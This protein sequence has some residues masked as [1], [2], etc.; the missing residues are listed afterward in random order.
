MNK[1]DVKKP[2][3]SNRLILNRSVS[4]RSKPKLTTGLHLAKL[5]QGSAR[6]RLR[7]IALGWVVVAMLEVTAYTVLAIAIRDGSGVV[8][9]LLAAAIA[10]I[11]TVAV[12]RAGYLAGAKLA[13]DLYQ[14]MGAS[15]SRAKLAWFTEDHRALVSTAAGRSVPVLMG[16]PAHQLQT[17]ILAPLVPLL[18]VLSIAIVSGVRAAFL[19]FALLVIALGMQVLAQRSLAR[20]DQARHELEQGADAATLELVDQLELLRTAAGS[21]RALD[22]ASDAWQKQESAMARSNSAAAPATA[23]SALA[24]VL[25]LAGVLCLLVWGGGFSQPAAALALIVLAARASAPLDELALIGISLNTLQAHTFAYREV[26]GAPALVQPAADQSRMPDG[27]ELRLQSVSHGPVIR[28]LDATVP[29]GST[30]HIAGPSGS[31]KSTLCGLLMRFDDPDAGRVLL[32]GVELSE[33]A[34]PELCSRMAYVSQHPVVFSGT[35]AE[36]VRIGRPEA[37]DDEVIDALAS[38][39]LAELVSRDNNGIYQ[40]VGTH[41]QALSG[42]ERQRVAIARALLKNAPVLLLDEATAALDEATEK[43]IAEAVG[44][45]D[46]TVI[47]VTHRDPAVWRPELTIQLV[48]AEQ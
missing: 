28:G 2:S 24:S 47:V 17:L 48:G 20:A 46:A 22:R 18:L 27:L 23:I 36:N 32:G 9:V 19:T 12:S 21:Q 6:A 39:Q 14:S 1:L 15:L 3:D 34:E 25:P 44:R 31:G 13:G 33:I 11:A 42:G 41:G 37:S 26:V 40:H 10:L 4:N 30:V 8:S 38:A 5:F 45:L 16:V 35:L 43:H 29:A 7:G